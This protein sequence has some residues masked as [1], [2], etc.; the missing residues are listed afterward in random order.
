MTLGSTTSAGNAKGLGQERLLMPGNDRNT[1]NRDALLENFAAE[2]TDVAYPI[3]LR[4]GGA[5]SWVDL[6]LD[7]WRVLG[8]TVKKW[9]QD[10]SPPSSR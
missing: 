8:E 5:G 10:A 6:E 2:L 4:H 3:A 9:G 1:G 7:L